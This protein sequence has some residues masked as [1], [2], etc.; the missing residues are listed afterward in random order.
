VKV[1]LTAVSNLICREL[2]HIIFW[3]F[4]VQTFDLEVQK[5]LP[6]T[7]SCQAGLNSCQI[8]RE[9]GPSTDRQT[10]S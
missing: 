1:H 5:L 7:K 3:T 2:F 9:I 4:I 6:H 8:K 10:V